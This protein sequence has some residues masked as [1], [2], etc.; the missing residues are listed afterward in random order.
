MNKYPLLLRTFALSRT[1]TR[2]T[3]FHVTKLWSANSPFATP[4]KAEAADVV[5]STIQQQKHNGSITDIQHYSNPSIEIQHEPP[6][7]QTTLRQDV[8]VPVQ[9]KSRFQ[10]NQMLYKT[11]EKMKDLADEFDYINGRMRL[12]MVKYIQFMNT[13]GRSEMKQLFDISI[14]NYIVMKCHLNSMKDIVQLREQSVDASKIID[15]QNA[16]AQLETKLSDSFIALEDVNR[17]KELAIK[18]MIP[19]MSHNCRCEIQKLL[20]ET[21]STE[22]VFKSQLYDMIAMAKSIV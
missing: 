10:G 7:I 11:I 19:F 9:Q 14:D 20:E 15:I 6:P 16:I 2:R 21:A 22:S 3:M 1:T 18:K 12:I 8:I 5:V 17:R 4:S 13:S